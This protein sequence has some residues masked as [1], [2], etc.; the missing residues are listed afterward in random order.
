MFWMKE[1]NKVDDNV[2][3]KRIIGQQYSEISFSVI[4][5]VAQIK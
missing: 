1:L 3:I 5:T 4:T 2:C